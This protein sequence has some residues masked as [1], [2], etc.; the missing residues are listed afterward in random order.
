MPAITSGKVLV[1]GANGYIAVW[2]VKSLLDTGF[3][4]RG[5]VRS[6]SKAGYLREHFKSFGD[7]LEIVVVEDI[8]KVRR[9]L[10]LAHK[11]QL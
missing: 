7:K 8:T 1:T 11:F 6:E 4:V 10:A 2:I 9:S 5:T 3:F